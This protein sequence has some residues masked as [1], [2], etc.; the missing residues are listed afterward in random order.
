[1]TGNALANLLQGIAPCHRLPTLRVR[2]DAVQTDDPYAT[3]ETKTGASRESWNSDEGAAHYVHLSNQDEG[4][5]FMG[6]FDK[7][8]M[9]S[10]DEDVQD[11]TMASRSPPESSWG[12][13]EFPEGHDMVFG[14]GGHKG[15]T[16]WFYR[17]TPPTFCGDWQRRTQVLS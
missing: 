8:D 5:A 9:V 7:A 4:H 13:V 6:F 2:F 12:Y 10:S 11:G 15:Q 14:F 3:S 16:Y 1:M 17:P